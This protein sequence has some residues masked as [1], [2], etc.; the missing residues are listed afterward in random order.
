MTLHRVADIAFSD[1]II[2]FHSPN[3]RF[4]WNNETSQSEVI[5]VS[6]KMDTHAMVSG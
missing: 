5:P 1:L 3:V 6:T 2:Q 4:V